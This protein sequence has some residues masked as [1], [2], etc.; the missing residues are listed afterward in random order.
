MTGSL[1]VTEVSD[2]RSRQESGPSC[3]RCRLSRERS[4][5][6]AAQYGHSLSAARSERRSWP[7]RA[8]RLRNARTQW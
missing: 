3:K 4:Q 6:V 7:L 8:P 2:Q 1:V 5:K